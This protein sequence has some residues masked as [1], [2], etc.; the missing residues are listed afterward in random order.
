MDILKCDFPER[1]LTGRKSGELGCGSA[2]STHPRWLLAS[3]N[4][5]FLIGP[6]R[7]LNTECL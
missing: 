7:R 3:L 2:S 1:V 4:G 5:S 6:I